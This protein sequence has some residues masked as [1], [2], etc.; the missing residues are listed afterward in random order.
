[1]K[2]ERIFLAAFIPTEDPSSSGTAKKMIFPIL[3]GSPKNLEITVIATASP[4]FISRM[5]LPGMKKPLSKSFFRDI[6]EGERLSLA[7]SI[8]SIF[9]KSVSGSKASGSK[10]P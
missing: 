4:L 3:P 2:S 7:E 8:C 9:F 1:M 10:A 6:S 5:P